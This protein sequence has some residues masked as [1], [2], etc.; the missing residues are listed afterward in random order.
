M[1]LEHYPR[2]VKQHRDCER[3]VTNRS[4]CPDCEGH[5][6]DGQGLLYCHVCRWIGRVV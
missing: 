3:V 5:V 2:G 4:M 1:P 6:V